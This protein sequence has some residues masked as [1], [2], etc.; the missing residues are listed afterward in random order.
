VL[1]QQDP[2]PRLQPTDRAILATLSRLLPRAR[3]SVFLVQTETLLR[4]HRR[5]VRRRWTYSTTSNGRPRIP[6]KVQQLVVR[7][8]RENSRWGY[9]R[10]RGELLRLGW[11]VSDNSIRRLPRV[12]VLFFI[13][14]SG[15][16]VHLAGVTDHPSGAWVAQQA[17]NL[18]ASL[19]DR[20]LAWK[21]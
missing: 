18:L 15:G 19:G 11:R 2:R 10:I 3:W 20:A 4:W 17:R 8:A 9:Q 5:M 13:E 14:L 12:Y 7:L 6:Q 1:R 21:F 16:R